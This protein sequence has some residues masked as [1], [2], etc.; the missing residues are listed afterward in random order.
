TCED[1]IINDDCGGAIEVSCGSSTTGTTEGATIDSAPTCGTAIT[2]PGVWYKLNDDSG[3]P[4]EITVS[5]CN[6]T[7]FDSKISVYRGSCAA[8]IC[9]DGNDDACGLQSEVTFATDGNTEY[10]ILIHSFGGA[11]GNFTLDVTCTPTPPP[12]DRIVNSIDVDEIG[13]PY[14]D[15]AVAM[16]AATTENG[17]PAGCDL[18][19]ANGV[20]YNF[21]A[22]A[23]GTANAT[24]VTPGGASSVT[25]YT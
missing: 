6:G 15:P 7:D 2:S 10:Y 25:F 1:P 22:A 20:W 23:D 9:V 12:N 17:N 8:L 3:L 13:F 16:P 4:G 24:I 18:T 21:V 19:G 11:T 14:T 5:L